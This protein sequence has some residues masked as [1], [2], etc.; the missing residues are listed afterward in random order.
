M[1]KILCDFL[2]QQ[3]GNLDLDFGRTFI[4]EIHSIEPFLSQFDAESD[5]CEQLVA[6]S[7]TFCHLR[8]SAS[9]WR[10]N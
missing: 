1:L 5:G 7:L 4:N 3:T 8:I 2:D 6:R 9:I 10:L